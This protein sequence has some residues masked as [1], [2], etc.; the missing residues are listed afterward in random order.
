MRELGP[1]LPFKGLYRAASKATRLGETLERSQKSRTETTTT[2]SERNRKRA[3]G[4][5]PPTK[6]QTLKRQTPEERKGG[7]VANEHSLNEV[8]L[9][10]PVF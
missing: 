8:P 9:R 3:R 6:P 2:T 5:P 1:F 10:V 7:A 4:E